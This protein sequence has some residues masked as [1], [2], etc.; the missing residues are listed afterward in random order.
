MLEGEDRLLKV[1]L[2]PRMCCGTSLQTS[3]QQIKKKTQNLRIL[4]VPEIDQNSSILRSTWQ[5]RLCLPLE[6]KVDVMG[7][8]VLSFWTAELSGCSWFFWSGLIMS[9]GQHCVCPSLPHPT[10]WFHPSL[11][12]LAYKVRSTWQPWVIVTHYH[13]CLSLPPLKMASSCVLYVF[14]YACF[15]RQFLCFYF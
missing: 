6:D 14:V 4:L 1:V 3:P 10:L 2:W 11:A 8:V 12:S 5:M 13:S 9:R 7:S 15:E